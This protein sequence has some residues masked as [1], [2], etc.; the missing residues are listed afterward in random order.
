MCPTVEGPFYLQPECHIDFIVIMVIAIHFLSLKCTTFICAKFVKTN[1][2]NSIYIVTENSMKLLK[3]SL[4]ATCVASLLTACGGSSSS[5][6]GAGSSSSSGGT[7]T[8]SLSGKAAD[9]YLSGANVCLDKNNNKV[10]DE[11]E[12]S[13]TSDSEGSF[14]LEGVA[15]SD[16][17]T[18]PLL[19]EVIAGETIDLDN[20]GVV[21]T[22]SY[23]MSA[24]VGYT[25][26]SPLTTLVQNEIE[27]GKTQEEAETQIKEALGTTHDL[28]VDYVAAQQDDDLTDEEKAEFESLHHI[29]QVTATI[30]AD[31]M[32]ALEQSSE[33]LNISVDDLVSLIVNEVFAAL[34]DIVLQVETLEATLAEGEVFNV[35]DIDNEIDID[36]DSLE[37]QVEE[38]NAQSSATST[39]MGDLIA[40]EG[41]HW[42]EGDREIEEHTFL[43]YGTVKVNSEGVLSDIEYFLNETLD[44]FEVY[45]DKGDDNDEN[46]VLAAS[47]WV[48]EN[49]EIETV[50]INDDGSI[51]L[52]TVTSSLSETITG[53]EVNL[54]GLAVAH[55]LAGD[56]KEWA[57]SIALDA[58]VFPAGARG[59]QLTFSDMASFG[60]GSGDWCEMEGERWVT[61]NESCNGYP[62]KA[63][64]VAYS[65][66]AQVFAVTLDDLVAETAYSVE[67]DWLTFAGTPVSGGQGFDIWMELLPSGVANY[68][69]TTW[70]NDTQAEKLAPGSWEDIVVHGVTIRKITPSNAVHHYPDTSW[71]NMHEDEGIAYLAVKD[72]FVR[73]LWH[74]TEEDGEL[75][76]NSI[77][78]EHIIASLDYE[79]LVGPANYQACLASL[80]DADYVQKVGD[81]LSYD[82]QKSVAWVNGGELTSYTETFEYMG[83]TFSW[84]TDI[85]N[86]TGLPSWVSGT[87]G[88]L[89]K[90]LWSANFMDGTSAGY[91]AQY[92]DANH[93]YGEEGVKEDGSHDGWGNMKAPLPVMVNEADRLLEET[94]EFSLTNVKVS[95]LRSAEAGS[96]L[97]DIDSISYTGT[98]TYLGKQRVRV[99]AG[100]F[101]T[102]VLETTVTASNAS[103]PDVTL[104]WN[105]NRGMVQQK[106]NN[107]SWAPIYNRQATMLP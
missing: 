32:D 18:Y 58:A 11:G 62:Y 1:D 40:G 6:S 2:I 95:P 81:K 20:A 49:D 69:K 28:T 75:V 76:F 80:P 97:A 64:N 70:G 67:D 51:T 35:A 74:D 39:N 92:S 72:G 78:K 107:P 33:A 83:N 30:I 44:G 12:P 73:S 68:F 100:E 4:V 94:A 99:P 55:T 9:G 3:R 48:A 50:T 21:L 84:L 57:N 71:S 27:N 16:I 45:V 103:E 17:D 101:E 90:T 87:D 47:G 43:E 96:A 104:D 56:N 19:V 88:K 5:D 85:T 41:L 26:I 54:E 79:L 86:V 38:N 66:D 89:S 82:A 52:N 105:V 8:T 14:T 7:T 46:F 77:A 23:T 25:F 63:A 98:M 15:Q 60:Y 106:Q 22:K 42:F 91:E 31:N 13:A 29:A 53:K 24:P 102:C 61:L 93:Y 10:C 34:E 59:Y 36:A 65:F 37:E